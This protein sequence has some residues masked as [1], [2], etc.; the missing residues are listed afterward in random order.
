MGR[1]VYVRPPQ[2]QGHKVSPKLNEG[3]R[4]RW[5]LYYKAMVMGLNVSRSTK[6]ATMAAMI[7]DAQK[8]ADEVKLVTPAPSDLEQALKRAAW[9][10][11]V[12]PE[13]IEAIKEVEASVLAAEKEELHY[14][15]M[16]PIHVIDPPI[17]LKTDYTAEATDKI[18]RETQARLA[19]QKEREHEEELKQPLTMTFSPGFFARLGEVFGRSLGKAL[20]EGL[21]EP[22]RAEGLVGPRTERPA[23]SPDPR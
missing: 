1:K 11:P 12:T 4:A 16:P 13:Q 18:N 9:A 23:A 6:I 5:G 2:K 14:P 19:A 15:W 20:G 21:A 17:I 3:A 8:R 7:R 10:V 22:L